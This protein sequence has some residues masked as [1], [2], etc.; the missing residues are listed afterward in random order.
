MSGFRKYVRVDKLNFKTAED[1][2][3]YYS[4]SE[5]RAGD[6]HVMVVSYAQADSVY[7]GKISNNLRPLLVHHHESGAFEQEYKIWNF[8]DSEEGTSAGAHFPSEVTERMWRCRS[9]MVI[10]S[11]SYVA[12]HFCFKIELPFLLWRMKHHGMPL[13]LF[14]LNV[15]TLDRMPITIP[16]V[17]G[18]AVAVDLA[19]IVDDRNPAFV[20]HTGR[21]ANMMFK[22]LQKRHSYMAESRLANYAVAIA[23]KLVEIESLE[24]STENSRPEA[25]DTDDHDPRTAPG[26]EAVA[27]D[28]HPPAAEPVRSAVGPEGSAAVAVSAPVPPPSPPHRAA[29]DGRV[30]DP[31]PPTAAAEPAA[32]D[33]PD[34]PEPD[35]RVED[36][37]PPTAAAES[38]APDTPDT[39]EPDTASVASLDK[40]TPAEAE[41]SDRREA[42][43][44]EAGDPAPTRPPQETT[45]API[46]DGSGAGEREAKGAGPA[47]TPP[48]GEG[49]SDDEPPA[50]G[51][52]RLPEPD[53]PLPVG[54][55]VYR[56]IAAM[57]DTFGPLVLLAPLAAV[58]LIGIIVDSAQPRPKAASVSPTPK[59]IQVS[60]KLMDR[61]PEASESPK[62]PPPTSPDAASADRPTAGPAGSSG[63]VL[64]SG[65]AD[66]TGET[67]WLSGSARFPTDSVAPPAPAPGVTKTPGPDAKAAEPNPS[68]RA[69]SFGTGKAI[70]Y[71]EGKAGA[72]ADITAGTVRWSAP[73][74]PIGK[75]AGVRAWEARVEIPDRK[76]TLT[77]RMR[78]NED[79]TFPA[80]HV[81]ELR[82]DLPRGYDGKSVAKVPGLILKA[83]EQHRGDPLRGASAKVSD[84]FF[85]VALGNSVDDRGANEKLLVERG[86]NDIPVLYETGRRAILTLEKGSAG[87]KAYRAASTSW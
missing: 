79:A 70:L 28:P 30:E 22:E 62:S 15:T 86:W 23:E 4:G 43:D 10:F 60:T 24:R 42:S 11:Q 21:E 35:G 52:D 5:C 78:T 80:S 16:A 7:F 47:I 20:G 1:W 68:V 44:R 73:L 36:P 58:T 27:T 57:V 25:E 34:V 26:G 31:A 71:E 6:Q 64:P 38:A 13:F 51:V 33:G 75:L 53:L 17:G 56:T 19:T 72:K 32:S 54:V 37:A 85:W 81:F 61:V 77:L 41:A 63:R 46:T 40:P 66:I 9:A 49:G 2:L 48:L 83:T 18:P 59:I 84:N 82:F 39:A 69:D 45:P 8:A 67:L 87:E 55:Q 65:Y 12:S 76:L 74:A 29:L 14:R 3:K 50:G